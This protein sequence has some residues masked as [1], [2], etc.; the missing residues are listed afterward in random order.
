MQ[1]DRL[2]AVLRRFAEHPRLSSFGEP[3]GESLAWPKAP[4]K[5]GRRWPVKLVFCP[6]GHEIGAINLSCDEAGQEWHLHG[7]PGM[8]VRAGTVLSI[9]RSVFTCQQ[10]KDQQPNKMPNYPVRGETLLDRYAIAVATGNPSLRL[11]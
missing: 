8:E 3:D 2:E 6:K 5:K 7:D 9:H 10:C 11:P 1:L 4:A